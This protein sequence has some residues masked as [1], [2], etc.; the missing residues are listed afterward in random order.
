MGEY[1][2]FVWPCYIAVVVIMTALGFIS[3]KSKN[4]DEKKLKDLSDQLETMKN[5]E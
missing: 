1:A 3:W 5:Q 4:T 2:Y